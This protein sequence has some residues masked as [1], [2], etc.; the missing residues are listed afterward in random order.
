MLNIKVTRGDVLLVI[1]LFMNFAF[2]ALS[3]EEPYEHPSNKKNEMGMSR[4]GNE[5]EKGSFV[6]TYNRTDSILYGITVY[7]EDSDT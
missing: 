4:D 3:I 6:R 7:R 1:T 2:R 5:M